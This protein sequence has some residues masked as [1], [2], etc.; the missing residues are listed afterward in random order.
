MLRTSALVLSP[1]LLLL[2][3]L[4][5]TVALS[6]STVA[7]FT[8]ILALVIICIRL[9]F[10]V[11][12]FSG[13]VVFDVVYWGVHK[14]L[15]SPLSFLFPAQATTNLSSLHPSSRSPSYVVLKDASNVHSGIRPSSNNHT[16][17]NPL[18]PNY[19]YL[20][21]KKRYSSTH[22]RRGSKKNMWE[23]DALSEK[24]GAEGLDKLSGDALAK[25]KL[26]DG[27]WMGNVFD[28]KRP[29]SKR[30]VSGYM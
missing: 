21:T 15:L 12:E 28:V 7:M 22:K 3:P 30:S 26:I 19:N 5:L 4:L 11:L 2:S 13:G 8:S 20:S 1:I 16:Y 9:G 6:F 23:K 25:N 17:V 24:L 18:E 14:Y 29:L 27:L 10:L